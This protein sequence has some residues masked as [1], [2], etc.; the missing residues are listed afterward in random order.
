[1]P[2]NVHTHTTIN[3]TTT[4]LIYFKLLLKLHGCNN[5]NNFN[6]TFL[7][8]VIVLFVYTSIKEYLYLYTSKILYLDLAVMRKIFSPASPLHVRLNDSL[9]IS[10]VTFQDI[11]CSPAYKCPCV[12]SDI[13]VLFVNRFVKISQVYLI[14]SFIHSFIRTL[15][16]LLNSIF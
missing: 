15:G 10:L 12:T 14:H 4:P 6:E 9:F 3:Y 7:C 1:M 16:K 5:T 8:C 11:L 13:K 2:I